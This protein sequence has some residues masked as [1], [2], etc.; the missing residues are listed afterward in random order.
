MSFIGETY[1]EYFGPGP[2]KASGLHR[3]IFLVFQQP[4]RQDFS[5]VPKVPAFSR[6]YRFKFSTK[7]FADLYS[8][9]EPI[10]ANFFQAQ[11]DKYVEERNKLIVKMEHEPTKPMDSFIEI[12]KTV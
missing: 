8:L 5:N 7:D 1:Y 6:K 4:K 9:G 3:Y 10:A 11:W 12:N 2:P